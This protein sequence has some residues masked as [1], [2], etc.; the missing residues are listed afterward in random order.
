MMQL[1]SRLGDEF[2]L[3]ETDYR[4]WRA[5]IDKSWRGWAGPHGGV[6]AGLLV[7]VARRAG[8]TD[9]PVRAVDL[10]FLGRPADGVLTFRAIA[11]PMGRST[12]V[13]E[14]TADQEGKSVASAAVTFGR[15]TPTRVPDLPPTTAPEVP[16]PYDCV[17]FR[18]PPEIVPVGAHFEIRPAAGPLPLTGTDEAW[19]C[20]WISLVPELPIDAATLAVLADALPPGLFPTL[21]MPVA[22]PTVA[23][24]MHLHTDLARLTRQPVLVR[25]TNVSTGGGWSVDDIDIWDRGGALLASAR[26]TRRVLG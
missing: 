18:L 24:S 2:A 10:R 25:A 7:E 23:F 14:V 19:M 3:A 20:A 1:T 5:R 13:V 6:I 16:A 9:L 8:G 17:Q 21:T 4:I 11:H 26:Q 15:T 22:V 12:A